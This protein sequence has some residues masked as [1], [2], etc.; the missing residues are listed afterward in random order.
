MKFPEAQDVGQGVEVARS[1]SGMVLG[2]RIGIDVAAA[3]IADDPV[4]GFGKHRLLIAP[5]Q[6]AAGSRVQQHDRRALPARVPVPEARIDE[7]R[8]SLLGGHLRGHDRVRGALTQRRRGAAEEKRNARQQRQAG[9][10]ASMA[11]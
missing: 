6:S 8:H 10:T 11:Q 2:E 9:A 3:R 5:D 1:G 4:A 7:L